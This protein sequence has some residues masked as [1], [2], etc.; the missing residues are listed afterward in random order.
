[1]ATSNYGGIRPQI[2]LSVVQ[3]YCSIKPQQNVVTSGGKMPYMVKGMVTYAHKYSIIED[4]HVLLMWTFYV[5]K[6][7]VLNLDLNIFVLVYIAWVGGARYQR[8]R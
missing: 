6:H 2:G 8:A 4:I 3:E 5:T 1:M 7:A